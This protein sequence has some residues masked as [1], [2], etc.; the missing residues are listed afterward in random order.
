VQRSPLSTGALREDGYGTG[1][2][3]SGVGVCQPRRLYL[4]RAKCSHRSMSDRRGEPRNMPPKLEIE[5]PRR[6]SHARQQCETSPGRL[7]SCCRRQGLCRRRRQRMERRRIFSVSGD[8]RRPVLRSPMG[9]RL[10]DLIYGDAYCQGLVR[11]LQLKAIAPSG[12]SGGFLPAKTHR[13]IRIAARAVRTNRGRLCPHAE[14]S[15]LKRGARCAGS[16]AGAESI[17]A[18]SPTQASVRHR[19]LWQGRDMAVEA[20]SRRSFSAANHAGKCVPCRLGSQSLRRSAV[21]D[22]RAGRYHRWEKR[23][24]AAP[25]G[26]WERDRLAS[27]CGLGRSVP[28]SLRTVVAFFPDDIAAHLRGR[29]RRLN[30]MPVLPD[31][32]HATDPRRDEGFSAA[33][34]NGQL[35]PPGL[36]PPPPLPHRVDYDRNGTCR[37]MGSPSQC[38]S[39]SP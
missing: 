35:V 22:R 33:T 1:T 25:F 37:S 4:W 27:I 15:M 8:V 34:I 5:W 21:T 28:C 17:S 36:R 38:R 31:R 26:R 10:R 18:L 29:K 19:S 32:L 7:P 2:P 13:Q 16:R 20:V 23:A 12:P 6:S 14:A 9:L 39:R 30:L 24:T 11:D 3:I